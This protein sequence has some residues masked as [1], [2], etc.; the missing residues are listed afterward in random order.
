MAPRGGWRCRYHGRAGAGG[1]GD[2]RLDQC[3][4]RAGTRL[5]L[6]RDA[7][8]RRLDAVL[9]RQPAAALRRLLRAERRGRDPQSGATVQQVFLVPRAALPPWPAQR[10]EPGH[11]QG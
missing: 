11:R 5:R 10:A 1:A 6:Q 7:D 3:R 2:D 4:A 9:Q 8:R